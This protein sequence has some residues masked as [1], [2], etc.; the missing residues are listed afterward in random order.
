MNNEDT[1]RL[2]L[3]FTTNVDVCVISRVCKQWKK[4]CIELAMKYMKNINFYFHEDFVNIY[5]KWFLFHMDTAVNHANH[6]MLKAFMR[7]KIHVTHF[8]TSISKQKNRNIPLCFNFYY[9]IQNEHLFKDM[10][11]FF[12]VASK[13]TLVA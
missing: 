5:S 10:R 3:G 12:K 7:K 11:N 6:N 1:L 13:I 4:V 2:I 8:Y 9:R